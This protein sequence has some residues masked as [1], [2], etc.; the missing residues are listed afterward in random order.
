MKTII[1]TIIII[2][3]PLSMAYADNSSGESIPSECKP[4]IEGNEFVHINERN[5]ISCVSRS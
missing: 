1:L 3:L 4:L 5:K 2:I